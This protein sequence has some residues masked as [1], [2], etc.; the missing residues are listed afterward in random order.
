MTNLTGNNMKITPQVDKYS[1]HLATKDSTTMKTEKTI[2]QL[3]G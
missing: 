2:S 1:N 3:H